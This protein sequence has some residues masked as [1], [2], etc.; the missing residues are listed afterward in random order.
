M[1]SDSGDR[2][3]PHSVPRKEK[4]DWSI[5]GKCGKE[6]F[7]FVFIGTSSTLLNKQRGR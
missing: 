5:Y 4:E 1:G 6:G 7:G 3:I 2:V